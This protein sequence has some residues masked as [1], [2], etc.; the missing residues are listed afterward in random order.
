M[1]FLRSIRI[2]CIA[3]AGLIF[4]LNTGCQKETLEVPIELELHLLDEDNVS[5]KLFQEGE[6]FRFR[7]TIRNMSSN[8]IG[9]IPDF[10]NEDFFRVYRLDNFE[11]MVSKGKPYENLFCEFSGANFLIPGGE[12]LHF[13]ISWIPSEDFCCPPFCKVNANPVLTK[14]KY[15][16]FIE[17]P[18]NFIYQK[19]PVSI[20][21]QFKIDFEV[22]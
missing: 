13:E 5:T 12:E 6:N 1:N 2:R 3:Y 18:F 14:G 10:I 16:T 9:Y 19:N 15:F 7:F 8:D 11:G 20:D 4:L 21:K 22:Y 17:G